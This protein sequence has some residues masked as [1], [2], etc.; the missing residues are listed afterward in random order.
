MGYPNVV[1]EPPVVEAP[2]H[3]LLTSGVLVTDPDTR[4]TL[5]FTFFPLGCVQAGLWRHLCP[6]GAVTAGVGFKAAAAT[7]AAGQ[8]YEPFTLESPFEC[9]STGLDSLDYAGRARDQL[10]AATSQALERELWT[11]TLLPANQHLASPAAVDLTPGAGAVSPTRGISILN[12]AIAQ[13]GPGGRGMIHTPVLPASLASGT[14]DI[15]DEGEIL[16]TTVKHNVVVPGGGYPGTGPN[17]AAPPAGETW[18]YGTGP[19][20]IRLDDITVTPDTIAE[21]LDRKQNIV[22]Y[23]AERIGA[24]YWDGCCHFAVRVTT[25]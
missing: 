23:R 7:N 25:T 3:S 12:Q 24:T 6:P 5:G 10:A 20:Y 16:L 18:M 15:F 19:V 22:N 13:C 8:V 2:V 9:S 21:A 14:G 1:V 11:G 17:G 4:W